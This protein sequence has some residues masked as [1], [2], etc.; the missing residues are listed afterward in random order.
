[1]KTLF[2][3]GCQRAPGGVRPTF[4]ARHS[5]EVVNPKRSDDDRRRYAEGLATV[6]TPGVHS[7]CC[8]WRPA[9]GRPVAPGAGGEAA[10]GRGAGGAAAGLGGTPLGPG[11]RQ[12]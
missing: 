2:L 8:T 10:G 5:H 11:K 3:H 4:L 7:S 12:V 9:R 6:L 1:M